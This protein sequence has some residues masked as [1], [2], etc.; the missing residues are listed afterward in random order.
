MTPVYR[1]LSV[2][3]LYSS[4]TVVW[5]RRSPSRSSA[6]ATP[7]LQTYPARMLSGQLRAP[8]GL[9]SCR[10]LL[11][12]RLRPCRAALPHRPSA[13]QGKGLLGT[14]SLNP[15]SKVGMPVPQLGL[16]VCTTAHCTFRLQPCSSPAGGL[17][18]QA[19]SSLPPC[20]AQPAELN[21]SL[22]DIDGYTEAYRKHQRTVRAPI[23][24]ALQPGRD[25]QAA[26]FGGES[27]PGSRLRPRPCVR[28]RCLISRGGRS[29]GAR[30]GT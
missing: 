12:G 21:F 23:T 15:S 14:P 7:V 24:S 18:L 1:S 4:E 2:E 26:R 30:R 19:R 25:A 22:L 8:P 17:L 28:C 10:G 3:T 6:S 5:D 13:A 20:A 9:P 11:S 29:T 16:P 27:R